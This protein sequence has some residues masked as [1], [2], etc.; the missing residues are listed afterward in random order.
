MQKYMKE[1]RVIIAI[2]QI[3]NAM[4]AFILTVADGSRRDKTVSTQDFVIQ[5]NAEAVFQHY[6]ITIFA[7]H[8]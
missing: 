1:K 6:L 7:W 5:K 4:L 8:F 2:R 3:W